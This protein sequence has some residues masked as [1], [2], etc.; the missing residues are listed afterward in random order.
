MKLPIFCYY[1]NL[2][3]FFGKPFI[4]SNVSN[5]DD[6]KEFF[7]Q[8]LFGASEHLLNSLIENDVYFLGYFDSSTGCIDSV[9]EF[10][11]HAGELANQVLSVKFKKEG[12]AHES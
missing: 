12:E 4:E 6:F 7:R 2:G 11:F 1:N 9:K 5:K 10:L 3:S 8:Q